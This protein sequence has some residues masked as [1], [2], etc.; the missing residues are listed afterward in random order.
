MTILAYPTATV[1]LKRNTDKKKQFIDAL[2]DPGMGLRIMQARVVDLNPAV[3][4]AVE[5]QA[6]QSAE[7]KIQESQGYVRATGKDISDV[8]ENNTEKL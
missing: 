6:F 2:R 3:C 8:K 4:H 5:L 7:R 1:D